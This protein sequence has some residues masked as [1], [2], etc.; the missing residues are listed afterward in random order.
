MTPLL[1]VAVALAGGAGAALR[2]VLGGLITD[3]IRRAFPVGSGLINLTGSFA[4]G[5]LTGVAGHGWLAPEV[6]T[7]LGVGLLGGY[8]TFSTASVETVR[9]IEERRFGAA[10]GYGL[11]NLLAC[12]AAA[13]LGLWLGS[14]F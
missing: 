2:F 10:V 13:M 14:R 6:A 4:L 7:V 11:G 3:R 9:L 1:F 12:T 8:T 5:L